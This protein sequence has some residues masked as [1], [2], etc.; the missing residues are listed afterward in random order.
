MEKRKKRSRRVETFHP[1]LPF[2]T[3]NPS[4]TIGI[5]PIRI[6]SS[7]P[8]HQKFIPISKFFPCFSHT[9]YTSKKLKINPNSPLVSHLSPCHTSHFLL[10][11]PR[12][13]LAFSVT[14]VLP[15]SSL[16]VLPLPF[17]CLSTISDVSVFP[18]SA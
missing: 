10:N 4:A 5:T 6:H 12:L 16:I 17:H 14:H 3:L 11:I 7:I 1:S 13:S 18:V 15:F 9:K 8:L 2:G